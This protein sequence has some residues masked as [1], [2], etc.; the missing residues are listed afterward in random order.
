MCLSVVTKA[1]GFCL[2]AEI[3][4]SVTRALQRHE[5]TIK[6]DRTMR[7]GRS[8]LAA[9]ETLQSSTVSV[10]LVLYL[11][12]DRSRPRCYSVLLSCRISLG[13]VRRCVLPEALCP[14]AML[15]AVTALS[16]GIYTNRFIYFGV[17]GV[18]AVQSNRMNTSV[19]V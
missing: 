7:M 18:V 15:C 10:R 3:C 1:G 17:W 16:T 14:P 6:H 12:C 4:L 8:A 2:K 9:L 5:G 19:H 11:N 13:T